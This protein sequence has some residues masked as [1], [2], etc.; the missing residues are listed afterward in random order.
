[1]EAIAYIVGQYG[2]RFEEISKIHRYISFCDSLSYLLR[3]G[4]IILYNYIYFLAWGQPLTGFT[5][6]VSHVC[7]L[8]NENGP[9]RFLPSAMEIQNILQQYMARFFLAIFLKIFSGKTHRGC[10]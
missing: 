3:N 4:H 1:M 10:N 5:D 7:T 2:Q 9:P 8:S 6:N